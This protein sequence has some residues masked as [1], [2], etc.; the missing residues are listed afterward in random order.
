MSIWGKKYNGGKKHM[1]P[2]KDEVGM[3]TRY[4]LQV[5]HCSEKK[6]WKLE[7]E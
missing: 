5:A 7:Q 6:K 1:N 3:L 2:M 4:S